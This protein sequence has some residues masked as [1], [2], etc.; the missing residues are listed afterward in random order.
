MRDGGRARS[1]RKNFAHRT[2]AFAPPPFPLSLSLSL[3]HTN[4]PIQGCQLQRF[5]R[6]MPRSVL[7]CY[8]H[9]KNATVTYISAEFRFFFLLLFFS[10]LPL[11]LKMIFRF[12]ELPISDI[13]T[14]GR[15]V[16][17]SSWLGVPMCALP[18]P[19]FLVKV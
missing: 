14:I 5:R 1:D 7:A 18:F 4:T 11:F 2:Q 3:T 19:P 17:S 15:V 12:Y 8:T 10:G 13:A 16:D 9:A 6:S